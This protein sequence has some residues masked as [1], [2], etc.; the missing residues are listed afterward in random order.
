MLFPVSPGKRPSPLKSDVMPELPW[1]SSKKNDIIEVHIDFKPTKDWCQWVLLRSDA[2]WDHVDSDRGLMKEH[3]DLALERNAI[4]LDGGDLF[5]AMQGSKDRRGSKSSLRPEHKVSNYFDALID[6]AAEWHKPYAD[7]IVMLA[8]GN[9]ELGV[10][11]HNEIDLTHRLAR[12]LGCIP[13]EISGFVRFKFKYSTNE[14]YTYELAYHHGYG[15]GGPVTR[16]VI[17]TNRRAAYLSSDI[18]WSGHVHEAW[19]VPIPQLHVTQ[20]GKILKRL[21]WHVK[22]PSYK[23]DYAKGKSN[24]SNER[25]TPPKPLG[26]M[27]LKFEYQT[28]Q[29]KSQDPNRKTDSTSRRIKVTPI[30]DIVGDPMA[31]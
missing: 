24:W 28:K 11:K 6:S 26:C 7:N 30:P 17:Q 8:H 15:G 19:F 21:Q 27:W 14:R 22:T 20:A 31:G 13:M 18:V 1:R 23:D 9:H 12:E 3:L 2:H 10:K 4:I 16:D 29:R 5:C 25:G